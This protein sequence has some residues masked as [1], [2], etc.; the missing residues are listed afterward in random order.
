MAIIKER[1]KISGAL[2]Y[3][4]R[5]FF[6]SMPLSSF[7]FILA[8]P[9]SGLLYHKFAKNAIDYATMCPNH[10]KGVYGINAK[11]CMESVARRY[12]I[13][14]QENARWRVM[15]YT[16]KRDEKQSVIFAVRVC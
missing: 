8:P 10:A 9:F 16:L 5:I 7:F 2:K 1:K 13:K 4:L 15:R 14:P 3:C 12:G 6:P 11:H